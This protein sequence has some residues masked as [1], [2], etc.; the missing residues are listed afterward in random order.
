MSIGTLT[1]ATV[2]ESNHINS[3]I[4]DLNRQYIETAKKIHA[5]RK[6]RFM[7]S[8]PSAPRAYQKVLAGGLRSPLSYRLV[9]TVTGMITKDR[10]TYRRVPRNTHDRES[11]SRLQASADPMMQDLE[12]IARKPLYYN[13]VDA[14]VADGRGIMKCYRDAWNGFPVKAAE[15]DDGAYNKMVAD[16]VS[17]GNTHPLRMRQV[18]ALNFMTPTTDY[19]PPYVMEAGKRPTLGVCQ[20]Y[21]IK[22]GTNNRIE[23][24]PDATAFHAYELPRGIAPT[25][26]VEEI[27][28]DDEVYIRIGTAQAGGQVFKAKNDMGFKPYVWAFGETSSH[29]DPSLQGLSILYAYAGIEPWLNT[30]LTVL[31]SWGVIGGTPILYTSRK[32]PPGATSLPDVGVQ[33]GEIPLGKRIDLPPGGEIGFVQPPPV[34]RE[35][36]EYIKFLVDFLDRAGLPNLAYGSIGTRTPGTAFQGALEQAIARVNPIVNSAEAA[37]CDIIK[38][39]WQIVEQIGKPLY[40][41][42][43]GIQPSS[44]LKRR[45]LGR[46]VIDPADIGGYYDLHAKIRVGNTQDLIS[47]GMHAAFMKNQGLWSRDRA[48]EYSDV[49]SPFDEYKF[50]MRDRLEESPLIQ[51]MTLMEAL[52]EEPEFVARTQELA[53][54]G[55]DV[56]SLLLN[57][58]APGGVAA[59]AQATGGSGQIKSRAVTGSSTPPKPTPKGAGPQAAPAHGGKPAGSPK[60]PGGPRQAQGS[61]GH[62]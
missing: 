43:T 40:M 15:T 53:A 14:L 18:D 33:M 55:I 52:Q 61:R 19:D 49:D 26:D 56:Q 39:Q 36:L 34:G 57:T 3:V 21:G 27:W 51:Q 60:R 24:M 29:P 13:F 6:L 38:M 17:T 47:R 20:A 11:A 10:P 25:I 5:V 31:A 9:Q 12:R 32:L 2:A 54:Q 1:R 16:F 58:G 4:Q 22:F 41:T 28:R 30:M 7:K 46:F 37:L 42:G 50:I 35:V 62:G 45:S 8:D 23:M 44:K 59:M 48:M